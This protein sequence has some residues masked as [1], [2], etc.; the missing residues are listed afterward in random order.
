MPE[1]MVSAT[2]F[3]KAA[4]V[5]QSAISQALK[6]G[7]LQAYSKSGRRLSAAAKGPKFLKLDEAQQS[8]EDGRVRL[9]D[10]MP[11]KGTPQ[12]HGLVDARTRS[13]SLQAALLQMRLAREMGQLIPEGAATAAVESLARAVARALKGA[14]SWSEELGAAFQT[15]GV[16]AHSSLLRSKLSQ[17]AGEIADLITAEAENCAKPEQDA[18]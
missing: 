14:A 3:S 12:R 7:R 13:A 15:G 16:G 11:S 10:P 6:H 1:A 17:L 4:G 5:T 18:P 9:D 8:F 2:A